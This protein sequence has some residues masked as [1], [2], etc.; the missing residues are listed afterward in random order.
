MELKEGLRLVQLT[1]GQQTRERIVAAAT[2]CLVERGYAG[3]STAVV[4]QEAGVSQG[5]LFKHFPEKTALLGACMEGTLAGLVARFQRE[6]KAK[7]PAGAPLEERLTRGV[8]ALWAVFRRREMRAVFELYVAARTDQALEG[9]LAPTLATHRER[10]LNEARRLF[11]EAS[12]HPEFPMVIDAIVYAMQGASLEL[13]AP[14]R[15]EDRR[16]LA[17]FERMARSEMKRLF[18]GGEG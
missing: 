14:N 6:M 18:D 15:G 17:L 7:V 1:K 13:F 4:A 2:R 9:V 16:L 12:A 3:A 10:I 8:A 11:P 5:A